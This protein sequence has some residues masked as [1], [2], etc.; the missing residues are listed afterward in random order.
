MLDI[1]EQLRSMRANQ[2]VSV[3]ACT[4]PYCKSSM[5]KNQVDIGHLNVYKCC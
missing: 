3:H 4:C 1:A 2:F 5:A